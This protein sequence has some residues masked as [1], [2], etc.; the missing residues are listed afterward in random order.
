MKKKTKPTNAFKN[1]NK[2]LYLIVT[3]T[4]LCSVIIPI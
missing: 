1:E 4:F 2:L 3:I